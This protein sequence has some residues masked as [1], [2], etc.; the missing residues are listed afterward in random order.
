MRFSTIKIKEFILLYKL[1]QSGFKILFYTIEEANPAYFNTCGGREYFF[2][3]AQNHGSH[4]GIF[5][6]PLLNC[7]PP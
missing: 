1:H 5:F 2:T 7:V 6:D 4:R 3:P